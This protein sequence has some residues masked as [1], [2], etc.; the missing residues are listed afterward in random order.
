MDSALDD[1][2][3]APLGHDSRETFGAL[4][5]SSGV[6]D[7]ATEAGVTCARVAVEGVVAIA[8]RHADGSRDLI[9]D[10]ADA[11]AFLARVE[12]R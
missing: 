1:V 2:I 9:V 10:A 7:E 3:V 8:R 12:R 5:A 4:L 11:V 6:L